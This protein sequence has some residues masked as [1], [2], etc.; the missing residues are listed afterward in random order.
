[1][2]R[3]RVAIHFIACALVVACS[4]GGDGADAA[5]DADASLDVASDASDAPSDAPASDAPAPTPCELADASKPYCLPGTPCHC[6]DVPDDASVVC[7]GT[8]WECAP[9]H[10]AFADCHG[11][12]P[13]PE[14]D[15]GLADAGAD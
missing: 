15:A 10:T 9:G 3:T 13:G 6:N 1:M 12:P 8:T 2:P 5:T 11:V 4:N 14:C 7:I